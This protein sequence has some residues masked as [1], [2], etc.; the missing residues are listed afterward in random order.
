MKTS[1][2][3]IR[4]AAPVLALLLAGCAVQPNGRGGMLVGIDN[5][6]LFGTTLGTFELPGGRQAVLRR[7]PASNALSVKIG[8]TARVVP[9]PNATSARIA[10]VSTIGPSTVAVL[11]T[12]ERGCQY[13]YVLLAIGRDDVAQWTMGDCQGRPRVAPG[14]SGQTLALEFLENGQLHRYAYAIGDLM[15]ESRIPLPPGTSLTRPFADADL[16]AP[17][18]AGLAGAASMPPAAGGARVIPAPP[19]RAGAVAA[20]TAGASTNATATTTTTATATAAATPARQAAK[21]PA[22]T[23]PSAQLPGAMQI[24]AD[25]IKPVRIDLRNN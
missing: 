7:D 13:R 20:T 8:G 15:F 10:H 6:E 24:P 12:Q 21:R 22:R 9:L 4:L 25:E 1:S 18:G 16:R 14:A 23:Q 3:L 17:A 2:L 19:H 11:E 5:A